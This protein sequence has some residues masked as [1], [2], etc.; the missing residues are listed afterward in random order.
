MG[1]E[2]LPDLG[3]SLYIQAEINLTLTGQSVDH[4][5]IDEILQEDVIFRG[6]HAA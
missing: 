4:S 1:F 2:N 6:N 3:D 5:L